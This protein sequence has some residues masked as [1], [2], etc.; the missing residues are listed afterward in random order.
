MLEFR[1]AAPPLRRVEE[2]LEV[3]L[4][5]GIG[6]ID[7]P[8]GLE[9]LV[10]I[11]NRGQIGGGVEK[12]AVGFP[13]EVRLLRDGWIAH[14]HGPL[15]GFGD[16]LLEEVLNDLGKI[17]VVGAF[18]ADRIEGDPQHFVDPA[19]MFGGLLA[20]QPPILHPLGVARL[21]GCQFGPGLIHFGRVGLRLLV[22]LLI[23]LLELVD[24][25]IGLDGGAAY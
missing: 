12:G 18:P 6:D 7:D 13:D 11:L 9:F 1:P 22:A 21:Q 17:L 8:V 19:E 15:A 14:H 10:P 24:G 2:P 23:K 4:L 5:A 25:V 16:F 20:K 3:E